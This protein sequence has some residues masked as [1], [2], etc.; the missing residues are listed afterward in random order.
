MREE[1]KR[2]KKKSEPK[3]KE[4]KIE[5]NIQYILLVFILRNTHKQIKQQEKTLAAEQ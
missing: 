2:R 5:R 4:K 3:E 1:K